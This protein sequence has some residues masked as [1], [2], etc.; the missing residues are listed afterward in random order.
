MDVTKVYA[1]ATFWSVAKL[2]LL[3][4]QTPIS[5][6][7]RIVWKTVISG[8]TFS[9]YQPVLAIVVD[10]SMKNYHRNRSFFI[11]NHPILRN[12]GEKYEKQR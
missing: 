12:I 2:D 8:A 6:K 4:N 10:E 3:N 9:Y 5:S 11:H 1:D 7:K